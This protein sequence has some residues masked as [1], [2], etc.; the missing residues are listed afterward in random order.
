MRFLIPLL[1]LAADPGASIDLEIQEAFD[2]Y[3]CDFTHQIVSAE[4]RDADINYDGWP[5]DWK[6]RR[7]RGFPTYIKIGIVGEAPP[8]AE[9]SGS[10]SAAAAQRWLRVD[11]D[12]GA[13]SV[14]A[15]PQEVSPRFAYVL[16]GR[17]RT[18]GLVND[19]AYYSIAFYDANDRL[20]E[21][22][23]SPRIR[24][25]GEWRTVSIGPLAPRS[26][27]VRKA[28]IGLH[29]APGEPGDLRGSACFDDLRLARLPRMSLTANRVHH[30]YDN[31]EEIVVNYEA[32]GVREP[33]PLLTLRVYDVFGKVVDEDVRQFIAQPS[34]RPSGRAAGDNITY[35][36]SATWTPRITEPGYYRVDAELGTQQG[37][38]QRRS[39]SLAVIAAEKL[40][41][42]S[43]KGP[44]QFG[45]CLPH[46]GDPLPLEA[47]ASLATLSGVQW[48]KLPAWF[49]ADDKVLGDRLARFVERVEQDGVTVVG[50]LDRPPVESQLV[51]TDEEEIPVASMF[52]EK[53][54]W[55]GAVDPVMT[56]L[57]PI[58]RWW[59]LGDDY[60]AS[61]VGFP[62]LE[63]KIQ[64][65]QK[66][67]ARFGQNVL[68][69]FAWRWVQD[70]APQTAKTPAWDFL[71]YNLD[72]A[73]P[74][75]TPAELT[76]HLAKVQDTAH[77]RWVG[78]QPLAKEHYDLQTRSRDLVERMLAA[79]ISGAHVAFVPRPFDPSSGLMTP[80]GAPTELFP[81]WR[82]TASLLAGTEYL[83]SIE[84]PL[85]SRNFIFARG[86]QSVMIVWN[87]QSVKETLYLGEDV[88]QT[89]LWSRQIVPVRTNEQ[90]TVEVGPLPTFVTGLHTAIARWRMSFKFKEGTL[91]SILGRQ[92]R[93]EY[94][95]ANPFRQGVTGR[96]VFHTPDVWDV[97][98]D[99][100]PVK[101]S[102]GENQEDA[103]R[104]T[105]R[106][107]AG[108]GQQQ[109]RADF[110]ITA[111]REYKFSVWQT[112]DV[113][114]GELSMELTTRVD[115]EGRLVVEQQ[116]INRSN[117]SVSFLCQLFAPGRPRIRRPVLDL[118]QGRTT[119]TY[120]LPNGEELM[121][122]TLIL[123]AEEID[124][125]R[126]LNHR[127]EAK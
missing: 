1:I 44:G 78:L 95:Y 81:V 35:S 127:F 19:V 71:A 70:T 119:I 68:V 74:E 106:P 22:Y 13:A 25:A 59:Q 86:D 115:E 11:L 114:L 124:G 36:G 125:H 110:E 53:D 38:A 120:Y 57:T 85:G 56:R 73:D 7:G 122:Q 65:I 75:F 104:V 6:R 90:H 83:G 60:D 55:Q 46:D 117:D 26:E 49:N 24:T 58:I 108:S 79:K 103:L 21:Q 14:F 43:F 112:V 34:T 96:I 51:F 80:D 72:P 107:T 88:R 10:A 121:G 89:D 97:E 67:L 63:A 30:V 28:V 16:E 54:A 37:G 42:A 23:D 45:W 92:Q 77:R 9:T 41:T 64:E 94:Q 2:V 12:G 102:A 111:D 87:E 100:P 116:F 17:L 20:L 113:G 47:L 3:R 66:R 31:P 33:N 82:T 4:T 18:D 61:F 91:S 105:L 84:T 50:V 118:N 52:V 98:R 93:L 32:S 99:R 101:L 62:N 27:Q 123:R 15:P 126:V 76:A 69:G 39:L 48:V 40:P 109:V 8:P 29:V 5:D